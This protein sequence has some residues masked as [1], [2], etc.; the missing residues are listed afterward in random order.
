MP[1]FVWSS[2]KIS[3]KTKLCLWK[4]YCNQNF[5]VALFFGIGTHLSRI[6]SFS[7][8][9]TILGCYSIHGSQ[10][11][12]ITVDSVSCH[13]TLCET[14]LIFHPDFSIFL[15][16][17]SDGSSIAER[18]ITYDAAQGHPGDTER[19]FPGSDV[20]RPMAHDLLEHFSKACR[21]EVIQDWVDCWAQVEKHSRDYVHVLVE[22]Q[23]TFGPVADET[24]CQPVCV[25]GGP[26]DCENHH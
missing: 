23:M 19:V 21:H 25:K 15:L 22:L 6:I 12:L 1:K 14:D 24:P 5:L 18:C 11:R 20:M 2:L 10:W 8:I 26:A 3:S 9:Q 17:F 13:P 7:F 16:C 4:L